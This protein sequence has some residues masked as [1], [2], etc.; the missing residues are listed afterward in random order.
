MWL[1]FG[2]MRLKQDAALAAAA[3]RRGRPLLR[4]RKFMS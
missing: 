3:L 1:I 4:G 2:S